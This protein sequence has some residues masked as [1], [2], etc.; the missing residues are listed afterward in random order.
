MIKKFFRGVLRNIWKI[1]SFRIQSTTN[2]LE[3]TN[4]NGNK[5]FIMINDVI[6]QIR[7]GSLIG[8][9]HFMPKL[10]SKANKNWLLYIPR[11]KLEKKKESLWLLFNSSAQMT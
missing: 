11:N 9:K 1:G 6:N 2:C 8:D 10:P 3:W 4:A 5:E 7:N